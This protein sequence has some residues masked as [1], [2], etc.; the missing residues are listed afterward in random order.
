MAL[1]NFKSYFQ[2]ALTCLMLVSLSA[3]SGQQQA[4][5]NAAAK[6]KVLPVRPMTVHTAR[7]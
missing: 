4:A 3:C 2:V 6:S 5:T 1:L 7:V